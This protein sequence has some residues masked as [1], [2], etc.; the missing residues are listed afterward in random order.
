[1]YCGVLGDCI[2]V[3]GKSTCGG[4][5]SP[6]NFQEFSEVNLKRNKAERNSSISTAHATE[7]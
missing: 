6:M 1:M 4:L 2:W 7:P 3:S 5:H